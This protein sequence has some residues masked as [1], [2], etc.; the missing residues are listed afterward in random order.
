MT[1]HTARDSRAH[2]FCHTMT[3]STSEFCKLMVSHKCTDKQVR[4]TLHDRPHYIQVTI[5][6]NIKLHKFIYNTCAMSIHFLNKFTKA[7]LAALTQWMPTKSQ[8]YDVTV[9]WAWS[10]WYRTA[11][12]LNSMTELHPMS[13]ALHS[14]LYDNL[15]RVVCK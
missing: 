9:T 6:M 2:F 10:V 15:N 8:T 14:S 7:S 13:L 5:I 1:L 12:P 11:P 4:V 3:V